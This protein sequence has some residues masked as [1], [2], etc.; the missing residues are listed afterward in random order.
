MIAVEGAEL[1]PPQ[2]KRPINKGGRWVS[3]SLEPQ[4]YNLYFR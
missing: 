2:A 3:F 1:P 4:F